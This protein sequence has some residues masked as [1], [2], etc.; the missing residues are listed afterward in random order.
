MRSRFV[1]H[2]LAFALLIG[3]GVWIAYVDIFTPTQHLGPVKL[4][5]ET[6][7]MYW[8][9][10]LVY[11]LVCLLLYYPVRR[12]SWPILML[13]HGVAI[14]VALASTATVVAL[15]Q[16]HAETSLEV[17]TGPEPGAA[18]P[19]EGAP[20]GQALPLP[21]P[22]ESPEPGSDAAISKENPQ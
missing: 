21:V 14:A 18:V 10:L 17:S 9:A 11:G 12:R 6:A 19:D 5:L 15:G 1:F 4:D 20:N 2:A 22:A 13:A 3:I 8:F 7:V 16:R